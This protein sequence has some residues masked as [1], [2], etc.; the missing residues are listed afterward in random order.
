MVCWKS[1]G[2]PAYERHLQRLAKLDGRRDHRIGKQDPS[3]KNTDSSSQ[4]GQAPDSPTQH[5]LTVLASPR[6]NQFS[7]VSQNEVFY[8]QVLA[9]VG[10]FGGTEILNELRAFENVD[11]DPKK[12]S[13]V[14]KILKRLFKELQIELGENHAAIGKTEMLIG[15]SLHKARE[16]EESVKALRSAVTRL[17]Q[18][19]DEVDINTF[20]QALC[21]LATSYRDTDAYDAS[22]TCIKQ[23]YRLLENAGVSARL[24]C[25]TLEELAADLLS[26]HR[27]KS[28]L[29][30]YERVVL[31]KSELLKSEPTDI[32]RPLIQ[33]S[34][35]HFALHNLD[36]AEQ[37]LIKAGEIF[38]KLKYSERDLLVQILE[39]LSGVMRHKGQFIQADL[40]EENALELKGRSEQMGGHAFYGHLLSEAKKAELEGNTS[41]AKGKYRDAL[42]TLEGQRLKRASERLQILAKL[43]LLTGKQQIVQRS[44]L[45]SDIEDSVRAIFCGVSVETF[46]GVK[47]LGLLY[48]LC[49]KKE[50]SNNLKLLIG[51]LL[52]RSSEI[53]QTQTQSQSVVQLQSQL[54]SQSQSQIQSQSQPNQSL[55]IAV[56]DTDSTELVTHIG[57]I[58]GSVI[59]SSEKEIL[60][61]TTSEVANSGE[62]DDVEEV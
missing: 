12:M 30:A 47:R 53:A 31:M 15:I 41:A 28:A 36:S 32:V 11:V 2:R 5:I 48:E 45:F 40:L 55:R 38:H 62:V 25:L 17:Q 22:R 16:V 44:S 61:L 34:I 14:A 58:E 50:H 59:E 37:C 6:E 8:E 54:Q 10:K 9:H 29:E 23:A 18:A 56:S 13:K 1:L 46:D 43:L 20:I 52:S 35:C 27:Y 33:L 24:Q 7:R 4:N 51:E 21:A 19:D 49:G 26:E 39:A 60:R 57:I 42:I 3:I